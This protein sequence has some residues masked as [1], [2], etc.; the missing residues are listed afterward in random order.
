VSALLKPRPYTM[1]S[2]S[3]RTGDALRA[4]DMPRSQ[5]REHAGFQ[6]GELWTAI[7]TLVTTG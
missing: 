5:R 1:L 2:A 7:R 6:V 4:R 3:S